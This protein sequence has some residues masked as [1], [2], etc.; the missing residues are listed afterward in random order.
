MNGLSQN[1]LNQIPKPI[2]NIPY[3]NKIIYIPVVPN[4]YLGQNYYLN[5]NI[6]NFPNS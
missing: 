1:K 2:S 3:E 4:N 5:R 6:S